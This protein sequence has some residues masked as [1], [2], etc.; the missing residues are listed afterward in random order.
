LTFIKPAIKNLRALGI[1]SKVLQ[2]PFKDASGKYSYPFQIKEKIFGFVWNAFQPWQNNV[3]FYFC[4]EERK[5]WESVMGW[6]YKSNEDF[7]DALFTGVRGKMKL[8]GN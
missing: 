1:K 4:M 2:I 6:S 7:E 8:S 5:L 3:F